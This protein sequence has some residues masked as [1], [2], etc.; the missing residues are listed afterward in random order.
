[1]R[2]VRLRRIGLRSIFLLF[3]VL[4]GS[5]GLLVGGGLYVFS[6]AGM[7]ELG[8]AETVGMTALDRLGPW[9]LL[10]F[11]ALYGLVGGIAGAVG[12]ALYNFAAAV[13]GGIRLELEDSHPVEVESSTEDSGEGPGGEGGAGRPG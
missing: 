4:Y 3:L 6:T 9:S 5:V 13:T 10:V 8:L 2:R 11:P 1:M 12:G 7:T